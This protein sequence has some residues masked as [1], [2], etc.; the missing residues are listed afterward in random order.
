M[1]KDPK[2]NKD[3]PKIWLRLVEP[4]LTGQDK[5]CPTRRFDATVYYLV[6]Q[7]L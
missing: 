2:T 7:Q 6:K 3:E 1:Y 4:W 5:D